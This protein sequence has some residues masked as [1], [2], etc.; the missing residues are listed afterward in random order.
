[1]ETQ[2]RSSPS[3]KQSESYRIRTQHITDR[4]NA[5][6]DAAREKQPPLSQI[7]RPRH[8]SKG[9]QRAASSAL[10]PPETF[11]IQTE[12]SVVIN[13]TESVSTHRT[14]TAPALSDKLGTSIPEV[15]SR[16][17]LTFLKT[18]GLGKELREAIEKGEI[19]RVRDFV[20]VGADIENMND[21][22][23]LTAMHYASSYGHKNIIEILLDSGANIHA[24]DAKKATPLHSAASGGYSDITR[25]L[26]DRGAV[27][28]EK[29]EHGWTPFYKAAHN[30]H[31]SVARE[32]LESG[33]DINAQESKGRTA[34]HIA[35][36]HNKKD[37]VSLLLA[38][39]AIVNVRDRNDCTALYLA[40]QENSEDIVSLLLAANAD[41]NAQACGGL[42]ALHIAAFDNKKDIVSLLL[43]TG[44]DVT[45]D[46]EMGMTALHAAAYS[47]HMEVVFTLLQTAIN[48]WAKNNRGK[49]AL[50]LA[51]EKGH[52]EVIALL[53]KPR[54]TGKVDS[55]TAVPV[56]K[57]EGKRKAW[58]AFFSKKQAQSG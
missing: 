48:V 50:D 41:I 23:G 5:G 7:D 44:A 53:E 34:L 25:L 30:G 8:T 22:N 42:T 1:V 4:S 38:A 19:A 47:G 13:A 56:T 33:A 16:P 39:D 10:P 49:T 21:R 29:D 2:E 27:I 18:T 26:L 9:Q 20:R 58:Q 45:L 52:S 37:I 51:K 55:K 6:S 36:L 11:G 15:P 57:E 3:V 46:T 32:L 40:A 28:D 54:G 12:P 24:Y 17:A 14:P 43:A 31:V 35:A